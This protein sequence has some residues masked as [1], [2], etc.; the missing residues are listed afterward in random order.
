MRLQHVW[1][2]VI[3]FFLVLQRLQRGKTRGA[4]AVQR[5]PVPPHHF[6]ANDAA[7]AAKRYRPRV[8][9]TP[10]PLNEGRALA[11]ETL[12]SVLQ[13][14]SRGHRGLTPQ[15]LR[16]CRPSLTSCLSTGLTVATL[17]AGCLSHH[18]ID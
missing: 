5:R 17:R 1:L 18:V 4:H 15:P 9:V 8:Y 12:L 3:L 2:N 14:G 13:L 10:S 6:R 16:A 7:A 11:K